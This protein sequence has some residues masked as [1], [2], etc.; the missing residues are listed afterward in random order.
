MK[1]DFDPDT[2]QLMGREGDTNAARPLPTILDE[3][4]VRSTDRPSA[5]ELLFPRAG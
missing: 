4:I 3:G 2:H 5:D 1:G